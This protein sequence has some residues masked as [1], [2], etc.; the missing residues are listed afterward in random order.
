MYDTAVV[1]APKTASISVELRI[2]ARFCS[3]CPGMICSDECQ[4]GSVTVSFEGLTCFHTAEAIAV[5]TAFPISARRSTKAVTVARSVEARRVSAWLICLGAKA[6]PDE[7]PQP[8]RTS[9][10]W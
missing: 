3:S 9:A 2:P 6:Y 10:W 5:P 1:M 7:G 8:A 4:R